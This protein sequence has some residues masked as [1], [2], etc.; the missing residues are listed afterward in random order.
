[1]TDRPSRPSADGQGWHRD[2]LLSAV[3][4]ALAVGLTEASYQLVRQHLLGLNTHFGPQILW[5]APAADLLWFL[6]V[7][8]LLLGFHRWRTSLLSDVAILTL[9]LL[10][11]FLAL[12]SL[13]PRL[14]RG[15][16]LLLALGLA[17][18][19]ARLLAPR[20]AEVM[21][22]V[23]RTLP[24]LALGL[25]LGWATGAVRAARRE[26]ASGRGLGTAAGAPNV[27]L[28]VL[29]T[30][31]S[32]DLSLYGYPRPTTPGLARWAASAT[33]FSRAYSTSPWTLPSHASMFT[34][35]LPHELSVSWTAPLDATYPTLAE[36]LAARGYRTGGFIANTLYC[37]RD[38]GLARG[39]QHYEDFPVTFGE[40]V[41]SSSIGRVVTGS[42][43]LRQLSGARDVLGRKPA[44]M[45]DVP[46]ERW[47][48]ADRSRPFFAFVN[49]LDAHQP[50]LP[51]DAEDA[52][53]A[54][55]PVTRRHAYRYLVH[56]ASIE[57]PESLSVAEMARER[58]AYDA[59]IAYLDR[60]VDQLLGSLDRAGVL[61]HTLVIITSDHGEQFG[62]HGLFAHGNS[63]YSQT[64]WVP[65]L[66]RLPGPVPAGRVVT[67]P[68]S[69]RDLPATVLELTGIGG[70]AR[71]PGVSW[72]GRWQ[73]GDS[74]APAVVAEVKRDGR[75]HRALVA[76]DEHY[77]SFHEGGAAVFD[78]RRDPE[79]REDLLARGATLHPAAW[80]AARLDSLIPP[81]RS[82]RAARAVPAS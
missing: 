10:P 64:L 45:V 5:M 29:D 25:A 42:R 53:F 23:R 46:V 28:I 75:I 82:P 32:L 47:I 41:I 35:R 59:A 79:E 77:L 71:F 78:I 57:H 7:A 8:L 26:S 56:E 3:W 55:V 24:V 52:A 38:F 62:E 17:L 19:T 9:L 51:P 73:A 36:A 4:L 21:R 11:P 43:A 70:D 81:E 37:G 69:L 63:V 34:G 49:F 58:E 14:H 22:L 48:L 12:G 50:Y 16:A 6:P 13:Y 54:T 66:V 40:V 67:T 74:L 76:G 1:M 68:V 61:G 72:S 39:F 18:Q 31:R 80:Y 44:P 33:V 2:L 15:A 30:V 60:R 20:R 65:L 27:L